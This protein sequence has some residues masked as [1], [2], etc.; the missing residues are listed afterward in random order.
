MAENIAVERQSLEFLY[1]DADESFFMNPETFDQSVIPNYT[2][3]PTVPTAN[4]IEFG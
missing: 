1:A 4:T 3:P 2:G